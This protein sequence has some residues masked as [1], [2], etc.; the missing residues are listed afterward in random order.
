MAISTRSHKQEKRETNKKDYN[1]NQRITGTN[2]KVT[3]NSRVGSVRNLPASACR[4]GPLQA[5]H[6]REC[7]F[8]LPD[9]VIRY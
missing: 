3:N 7:Q 5:L 8:N 6:H 1:N 2:K 4:G 9:Y